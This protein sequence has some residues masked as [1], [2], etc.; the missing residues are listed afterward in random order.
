MMVAEADVGSLRVLDVLTCPIELAHDIFRDGVV[1]RDTMDR[2]VHIIHNYNDLLNEYRLGGQVQVRLLASNVLLDVRNA[3][4]IVNRLHISC[5]LDLEIMD[6]GEMTRLLYLNMKGMLERHSG[7]SRKRVMVLH[8]GPGNTRI[9]LFDNGRITYYASYRMGAHRTVEAIGDTAF[10][11]AD[12]ECAVIREHIRG[13]IEQIRHDANEAINGGLDAMMIFG[14]DFHHIDTPLFD[15][16][17]ICA[18]SLAELVDEI[19]KTPYSQRQ[20]Q[21][22]E[23]YASVGALLS[24]AVTYLSLAREFNPTT[25]FY[26]EEEFAHAFLRNLMPSRKDD[27]ALEQ[28]VLH[29]STLLANRYKVDPSHSR[30]VRKL[31]TALFDQLQ[32]LHRLS[33]HDR[34]LLKV[35]AILHEIG[36]FINQKNHH[37]H[38]QYIILHSEIFGLS[39]HDI[40]IVG[41]MARYHRHGAPTTADPTYAKLDQPN[42]L[43]LQKMAAILRVADAMERAH[44]GRINQFTVRY[45]NRRVEL[46]IPSAH[47]LT[48]EN[49][50]M[51]SKADLF[52]DVFGYDIQLMP[53]QKY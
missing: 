4:T 35:S 21:Y 19:A 39:R 26:P 16:D 47:D 17:E 2:C 24:S 40:T 12:H 1:S 45:N 3:D 28:E 5:G 43:R 27:F 30:Q 8:V 53:A 9:L 15:G 46:L 22:K 23:D 44:S 33:R 49:I 50:A 38:G 31:S 14:P 29:F 20:A 42:R 34:L 41:L 10:G 36:T 51:R 11:S 37:L 6:D 48:V 32:E 52:A 7:L 25:L 13:V 18:E